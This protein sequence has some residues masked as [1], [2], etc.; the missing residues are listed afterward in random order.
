MNNEYIS[1]LDKQIDLM[2]KINNKQDT[3]EDW[4]EFFKL[5]RASI[6]QSISN[7]NA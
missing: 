1:F 6:K 4:A 7:L 3:K 2:R 5:A